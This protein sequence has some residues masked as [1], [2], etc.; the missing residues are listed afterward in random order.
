MLNIAQEH[1]IC[2]HLN[3][4]LQTKVALACHTRAPSLSLSTIGPPHPKSNHSAYCSKILWS[5]F[6]TL[7]HSFIIQVFI[8]KHYSMLLFFIYLLRFL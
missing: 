5:F 1:V 7:L 3:K 2:V 6:L 8:L 4:L